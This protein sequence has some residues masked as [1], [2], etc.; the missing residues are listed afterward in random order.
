MNTLNV[1]EDQAK[2]G[3]GA[4]FSAAETNMSP[5]EFSTV[6][7]ALPGIESLMAAAPM[8][9]KMGG[10]SLGG[11]SS[12]LGGLSGSAGAMTGLVQVFSQLGLGS[13]MVAKFTDIILQF[14]GSE[15]GQEVM[16]LLKN[17]LM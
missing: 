7:K 16:N 12:M 9:G 13:G 11:A 8:I 14:A 6:S 10:S 3:A 2:G 1:S 17:A 15:G 5:Q 4:V